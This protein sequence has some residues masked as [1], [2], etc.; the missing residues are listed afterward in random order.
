MTLAGLLIHT[1]TV[2]RPTSASDAHGS[3]VFDYGPGAARSVITARLQQ[4]Q[5]AEVS[6]AD[7]DAT[8]QT[9][10]LFTAAPVVAVG[11]RVEWAAHPSGAVVFDVWGP[12]EPA[13][14]AV[15]AVHHYEATLKIR[16][17]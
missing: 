12:P 15:P 7:R 9:W 14:G 13:Y 16:A 10:T 17:G 2:V 5:R 8:V 6:A 4:D 1:V 11:D 3:T